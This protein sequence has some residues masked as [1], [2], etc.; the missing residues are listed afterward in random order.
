MKFVFNET[1]KLPFVGRFCKYT[2]LRRVM[3]NLFRIPAI[4]SFG[5]VQLQWLASAGNW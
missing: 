2:F 3:Q 5:G 4:I 1:K